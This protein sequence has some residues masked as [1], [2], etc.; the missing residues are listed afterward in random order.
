M[1]HVGS[2]KNLVAHLGVLSTSG[3]AHVLEIRSHALPS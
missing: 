2:N 1:Y 3:H